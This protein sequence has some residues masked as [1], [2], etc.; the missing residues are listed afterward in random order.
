MAVSNF[1]KLHK[2]EK[3]TLVTFC[4][5]K[6]KSLKQTVCISNKKT[7]RT[8]KKIYSK[9]II[10]EIEVRNEKNTFKMKANYNVF[11]FCVY[12]IYFLIIIITIAVYCVPLNIYFL[13][14]FLLNNYNVSITN[15]Q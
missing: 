4:T 2:T 9:K 15:T 12:Y 7:K 1:A 5:H 8:A 10:H 11:V 6:K 13:Y 3:S 14:F